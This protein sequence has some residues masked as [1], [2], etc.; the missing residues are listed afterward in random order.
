MAIMREE[1][2]GP[3]LPVETYTTL[4]EGAFMFGDRSS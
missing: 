3:L 1:V 4:D 2:F